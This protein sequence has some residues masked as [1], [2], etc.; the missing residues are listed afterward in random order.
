[1][2]RPPAQTIATVRSD[3]GDRFGIPRQSGLAGSTRAQ[4]IFEP[5]FRNPEMV[6]GI[7]GFSHLWLIWEF[8]E[9][10]GH[11]WSPTA[12]PPRLGSTEGLGV[13]ATRS[14][15]R[16]NPIGLS[17]V[18]L[19]GVD[20][21]AEEGPILHVGGA[22]ILDGTPILDIKPYVPADSRQNIRAGYL[23]TTTRPTLSVTVPD[24]VTQAIGSDTIVGLKEV[25]AQD[26]R[27]P[28][29]NDPTR[30]YNLSYGGMDVRFVVDGLEL[31]VVD[32]L[33]GHGSD[34]PS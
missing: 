29:D 14:P 11:G 28:M 13:F 27:S 30:I 23:E 9:Y 18:V 12:R 31:T 15:R 2:T 4:I 24:S 16:P 6:R 7:D 26:P 32:V 21:D 17:S 34:R 1:M 22:D 25:L 3:F 8:S 33:R 20:V 5:P 10:V 19:H